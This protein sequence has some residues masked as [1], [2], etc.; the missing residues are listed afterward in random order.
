MNRERA[1]KPQ[2][3]D[4]KGATSSGPGSVISKPRTVDRDADP[5]VRPLNPDAAA[6]ARPGGA[7]RIEPTRKPVYGP[8]GDIKTPEQVWMDFYRKPLQ[9]GSKKNPIDV[10][11][12]LRETVTVLN[13]NRKF[14]DVRAA[15][16]GFLTFHS[17]EAQPWMYEALA[18][19][20]KMTRGDDSDV[21]TALGYAANMAVQTRNPNHLVSV[22]DQLLL[23]G[24]LDRAGGLLDQAADLVPQRAEPLLMSIDLAQRLKD[25]RR[26][27][28]SIER[29]L[30]LGWTGTDDDF[31]RGSRSQAETLAKALREENK[32]AEADALLA[33]LPAAEARDLFVRLTWSGDADLDLAVDEPWGATAHYR[34]P[35]T[36]FGGA[37]IK[38][39]YGSHPE[40]VYVCPRGFDGVYT[41]RVETIYNNPEKPASKVTLEVVTHEGTP[42]E[43][44]DVR[45]LSLGPKGVE[46]TRVTLSGG[47]RTKVM[48][49]VS[50]SA[51]VPP[52]FANP[53]TKPTGRSNSTANA[54]AAGDP[55]P[56]PPAPLRP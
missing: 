51:I 6:T 33:R 18:L 36:V 46:P 22:A 54:G 4:P 53:T 7:I 29:L 11:E 42:Q 44:K 38:N 39:G 9:R 19:A 20:I 12:D 30:S 3:Q 15:L 48:P 47:R 24:Y 52:F 35:R 49:Y 23:L 5:V 32:T 14:R 27:G 26:M 8:K 21:R 16:V 25:P 37:M 45:T 17:N 1:L 41:V 50:P 13:R 55:K 10:S 56:H 40:E 2:T 34:T 31:R 28:D 43:H